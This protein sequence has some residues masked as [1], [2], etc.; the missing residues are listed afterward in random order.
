MELATALKH[1]IDAIVLIGGWAPYY[2][3]KDYGR[4]GFEHIGSIDIDLAVDP[5]HIGSE[6]YA[7]II[8]IITDRGYTM[9][10]AIDNSPIPFS[11]RKDVSISDGG[12][13]FDISVDFITCQSEE[14]RGHRHRMV[15]ASLPARIAKGCE[16]AFEHNYTRTV[17][18]I[19]PG[20]G[21]AEAVI[22]VLDLP[23]CLGMK[24][25]VLGERYKEKDAYD[26]FAVI[27]QCLSDP[28]EVGSIVRPLLSD[29]RLR[30]GVANISQRFR[31]I[32]AEGPN[33]VGAFLH[34]YD[35]EL[36]K[37]AQAESFVLVDRFV[38]AAIR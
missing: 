2:L 3:I 35:L 13:A 33:W 18:G 24:G 5:D 15:Q 12:M 32:D 4:P 23:G 34:P 9:R 22:R 11:Y 10:R 8:E 6:E 29:G 20:N 21:R 25:I 14:R 26:I 31:S 28:E 38:G 36:R 27:S 17:E 30:E 16:L 37:R 19:L 7:T 1:Y